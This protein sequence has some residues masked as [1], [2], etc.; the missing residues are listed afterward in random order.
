MLIVFTFLVISIV[1][2]VLSVFVFRDNEAAITPTPTV[3][4]STSVSVSPSVSISVTPTPIP[5][6]LLMKDTFVEAGIGTTLLVNHTPDIGSAWLSFGAF[7]DNT[8]ENG[9][10]H[11]FST[12]LQ[13][14]W[15]V[16]NIGSLSGLTVELKTSFT[17]SPTYGPV[18]TASIGLGF[19]D[20]TGTGFSA[21]SNY[22]STLSTL[23][24]LVFM[25]NNG[26]PSGFASVQTTYTLN[27]TE[28]YTYTMVVS[29]TSL[30]HTITDQNGVVIITAVVPGLINSLDITDSVLLYLQ[31]QT[32]INSTFYVSEMQVEKL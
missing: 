11:V 6:T 28:Q 16:M 19:V 31:A 25:L 17:I 10:N 2:I 8:I 27:S 24:L 18:D 22:N 32:N 29:G 20:G 7:P 9:A 23:S 3:I 21:A 26:V 14:R 30:T 1:I 12:D 13:G 15:N 4:P 5:S